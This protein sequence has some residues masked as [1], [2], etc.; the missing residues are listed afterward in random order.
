M[1]D[2]FDPVAFGRRMALSR[3]AEENGFA[4]AILGADVQA[5][6][7]AEQYVPGRHPT[8][9]G[10][11]SDRFEEL[12]LPLLAEFL[13]AEPVAT[14]TLHA[15]TDALVADIFVAG[16]LLRRLPMDRRIVVMRI[17]RRLQDLIHAVPDR[18][19]PLTMS[20]G[21][22]FS[23]NLFIADDGTHWAIDWGSLGTG[24]DRPASLR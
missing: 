3:R 12:Y 6:W 2:P 24:E 1:T 5:G 15:Y 13:R 23:G 14:T 20:P 21:D 19:A 10:G 8:G 18:P 4:P 9:F 16:G 7:L 11:C 22:Y 17:V